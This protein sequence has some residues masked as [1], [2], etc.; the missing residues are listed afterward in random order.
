MTLSTVARVAVYLVRLYYHIDNT[1]IDEPHLKFHLIAR[2]NI[3]SIGNHN[4]SPSR[5]YFHYYRCFII[6]KLLPISSI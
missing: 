2:G 6:E 1:C 4:I 5:E 3:S